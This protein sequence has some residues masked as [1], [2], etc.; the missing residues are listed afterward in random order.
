MRA[1]IF[2]LSIFL[3][4]CLNTYAQQHTHEIGIQAD[5]DSFLGQGSDR[6]YTNGIFIYY[7][8]ALGIKD[9][10][11]SALANKVLGFETGQKLF[12]PISGSIPSAYYVD[13]PFAGYLY[14]GSTLNFLYKNESNLKLSAQLGAVGPMAL[15]EQ[16]QK[17]IHK[18]FG[19]Y[20]I[21]GWQYQIKNEVELNL[22]AE[23]NKLLARSSW[24]DVSFSSYA[25]LGNGFTGA[26]LGPLVRLGAFNQLFNSAS[27]QSASTKN[28]LI[29]P[30][31]PHELFFY[32]KPQFNYI[33]YDATVQGGL[34]EN[35]QQQKGLEITKHIEPAMFSQ[36]F[37]ATYTCTRWIFDLSVITHTRDVK[38]MTHSTHQWGTI[39]GIYRFK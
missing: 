4:G 7:R 18:T 12:N 17:F 23:Y 33:A 28:T 24:A 36:Q 9:P 16:V 5:N 26:G 27:T 21:M 29:K 3:L 2:I 20:T 30:L 39:T 11:S 34:F 8:Q 25:N 14:V 13:R 15:G 22:S 10:D 31:H 35:D 6:Y 37:G 19:F 1:K 38:E 32:Y